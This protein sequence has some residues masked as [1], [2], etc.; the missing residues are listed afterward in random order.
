MKSSYTDIPQS[1]RD[2]IANLKGRASKL[3]L[4]DNINNVQER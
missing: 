3:R 4:I 1:Y 2:K